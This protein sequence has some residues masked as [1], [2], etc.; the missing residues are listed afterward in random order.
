[1]SLCARSRL[2]RHAQWLQ[3]YLD[4]KKAEADKD[5]RLTEQAKGDSAI[6]AEQVKRE[7]ERKDEEARAREQ[8]ARFAAAIQKVLPDLS[9]DPEIAK[10][11]DAKVRTRTHTHM[12]GGVAG[13]SYSN[14]HRHMH[15]ITRTCALSRGLTLWRRR[16][17]RRRRY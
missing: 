9:A 1:M 10:K 6:L 17:R 4:K 5:A 12:R 2:T 7:A 8:E 16:R 14:A 11:V 13:T 3:R 15:A